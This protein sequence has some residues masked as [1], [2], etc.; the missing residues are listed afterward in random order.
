MAIVVSCSS[1]SSS[2]CSGM[3]GVRAVQYALERLKV[4]CEE[5]LCMNLSVE[6]VSDVLALADLHCA[7]QLRTHAI[8]FINRFHSLHS[9][10]SKLR[11][12]SSKMSECV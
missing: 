1:S 4:M 9:A 5:A 6:N 3:S 10:S 2:I 11:G 12:H 7:E 8:D